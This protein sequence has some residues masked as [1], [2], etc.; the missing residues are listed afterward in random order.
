VRILLG[1]AP[2]YGAAAQVLVRLGADLDRV[3]QQVIQQLAG[4]QTRPGER[5]PPPGLG[6]YDEKIAAARFQKD[7]ALDA[8]D[9]DRASTLRGEERRLL[10][11]RALR[12]AQWSAGVDVTA[13]G[14]E[15]DRLH[16]EV[17]RLRDLLLQNGIQPGEGHQQTT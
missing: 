7:A 9:F 3:P 11:E 12:L 8:H 2:V 10:D 5:V 4:R 14:E 1:A 13:L 17:A 15:I 16:Q 6:D